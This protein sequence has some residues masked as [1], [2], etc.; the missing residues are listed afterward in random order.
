MT[1]SRDGFSLEWSVSV[2]VHVWIPI[3]DC[4]A[5]N[6]TL[7]VRGRVGLSVTRPCSPRLVLSV[8]LHWGPAACSGLW[9]GTASYG[10]AMVRCVRWWSVAMPLGCSASR[11]LC[12]STRGS[13]SRWKRHIIPLAVWIHGRSF[14]SV[15]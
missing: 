3:S 9:K 7:G 12:G 1:L 11:W 2:S 10:P 13:A 6:R 14:G 15:W 4:Q 5:T 8:Y